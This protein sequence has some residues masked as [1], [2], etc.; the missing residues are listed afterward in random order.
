MAG[1]S[2]GISLKEIKAALND[3]YAHLRLAKATVPFEGLEWEIDRLILKITTLLQVLPEIEN[4]I[5][6]KEG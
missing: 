2:K 6:K 5:A 1:T 4:K 3:T